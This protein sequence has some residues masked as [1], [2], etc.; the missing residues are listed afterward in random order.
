[1]TFDPWAL[2]HPIEVLLF[3]YAFGMLIGFMIGRK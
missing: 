2:E 3:T 1:M